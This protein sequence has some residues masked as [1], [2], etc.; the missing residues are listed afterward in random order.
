M[1]ALTI[2]ECQL[3]VV[4]PCFYMKYIKLLSTAYLNFYWTN[5]FPAQGIALF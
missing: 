2:L 5:D 4:K 3:K 1:L